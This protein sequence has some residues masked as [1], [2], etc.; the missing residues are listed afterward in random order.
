[1]KHLLDN[2][3]LERSEIVANCLMNR[4]RQ[5]AGDNS[6]AAEFG[7]NPLEFVQKRL[8]HQPS[9]AWL[10]LCCGS[11][12]ALI[13][14]ARHF[15]QTGN[16]DR[17][18]LCG[19][20]LVSMFDAVPVEVS[21][22]RLEAA[23]LH[24]WQPSRTYDLITCVHGLHYLGDKLGLIRRAAA[25]LSRDGLLLAHLDLKNLKLV[26]GSWPARSTSRQL[27]QAGLEYDR[28]RCLLACRGSKAIEFPLTYAG[29]DDTAGP[30]RTGQ[31]A[32]DSYYSLR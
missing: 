2:A 25:W 4:Q 29:A 12:K 15:Q 27:Q 8:A 7:R 19:V 28:R 22:L 5:L 23:S 24:D 14:A 32:V 10:D 20:D 3:A 11:G 18:A 30:N 21:C 31:P 16:R 26:E 6:Y 1:M 9:V 13:Q 17:I